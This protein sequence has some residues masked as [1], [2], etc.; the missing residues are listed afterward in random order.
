M[1]ANAMSPAS[2]YAA[3]LGVLDESR[4]AGT[5]KSGTALLLECEGPDCLL[6]ETCEIYTASDSNP[7]HAEVVGFRDNAVLLM[8]YGD[9]RGMRPGSEVFAVGRQASIACGEAMLGRVL[10]GLGQAIDGGPPL[11]LSHHMPLHAPSPS[12]TQ[13]RRIS[14]VFESGLKVVDCALPVGIGQRVGIFSGSGVGKSTLLGM[15]TRNAKA[16]CVVVAMIGERGREV[17]DFIEEHLGE[18]RKKAVVVVATSDQPPLVRVHAALS[19][20]AIAEYF[21]DKGQNVLLLMDSLTRL[22][23]AQ[24]EIGL[25]AGEPPTTRGYTPSV[26]SLMPRLIERAG[27]GEK[28]RGSITAFYTVLVE[29][30]DFNEP[31][32]DHARAILDGHWILSRELSQSAH[33]PPIDLLRSNSRLVRTLTSEAERKVIEDGFALLSL[34]ERSRDLLDFGA[35]KPGNNPALDRAVAIAPKLKDFFKQAIH[36]AVPRTTAMQRLAF[37]L[38]GAA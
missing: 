24:R 27:M 19:A 10:N 37:I 31:L 23:M 34:H 22:A 11:S 1:D 26:F 4:R 9:V 3:A 16:D 2:H 15:L 33:Y 5:V 28:E 13:R 17:A 18:N 6:G 29:G 7:V 12:P 36:E 14:T 35:Y 30:D 32:T 25:A 38:K 20:T 8:P 21:R